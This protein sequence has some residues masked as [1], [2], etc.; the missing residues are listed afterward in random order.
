MPIPDAL[1]L[2]PPSWS[3]LL[4]QRV[5]HLWW[6]KMVGTAV[7]ISSFFVA[8]FWL[9]EATA[10]RAVTV[11][12]TALDAWVGL[13]S[14]ALV[15]YASL[16]LYVSLA[17]AFAA[18][19][20]ALRSYMVG[21]LAIIGLAF[22]TYW[23]FPTVTPAFGVDW[24]MY[25]VLG[26]LKTADAGGNAFPSL[27]VAFACYTAIVIGSQL[28]SI[29][30]PRWA[31]AINGAW[32]VAIAYSTLAIHQHVALDVVGGVLTTCVALRLVARGRRH[33]RRRRQ[34]VHPTRGAAGAAAAR[35][36]QRMVGPVGRAWSRDSTGEA[37]PRCYREAPRR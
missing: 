19:M 26:F 1:P 9:M 33:A 36:A 25:P 21:A 3:H 2:A 23:V 35:H 27:H 16:W 6:I 18:N 11:P 14:W 13:N 7:S 17:P 22:A 5:C 15:P 34:R 4:W 28:R 24:A 12:T 29:Q 37:A 30:A 8:Y 10:H 20:G 31:H 32:C